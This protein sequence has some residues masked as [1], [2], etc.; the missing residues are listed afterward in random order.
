[1]AIQC[2][3]LNSF[4]MLKRRASANG[5]GN[6][7]GICGG[8]RPN[9]WRSESAGVSGG[10]VGESSVMSACTMALRNGMVCGVS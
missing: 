5:N 8:Y 4:M 7:N 9:I 6:V 3:R 10:G 1:M 2:G